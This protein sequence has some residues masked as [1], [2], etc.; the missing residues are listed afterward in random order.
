MLPT[1][2]YSPDPVLRHPAGLLREMF[3]S[4]WAGRELAWRLMV[5]NI[6]AMYR[7]TILGYLWAFLP[8]IVAAGTF[9][10]LNR[11]GLFQVGETGIPYPAWVLFGTFLWQTFADSLNNPMK[12]VSQSK[13]MLSKINFPREA[14]I[15]A[16]IGETIFNFGVRF[17]ILIPV[18]FYFQIAVDPL[19][20]LVFPLFLGA[21][22]A[23]GTMVGVLL[24]PIAVLYQ[25]IE[26]G[27]PMLLPFLMLFSG[28]VVP[29]APH[30]IGRTIATFNPILPVLET[31]RS[32]L[33]G[34]AADLWVQAAVVTCGT[35]LLLFI[36]WVLFRVAMPHLIAR[37]GG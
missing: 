24:T 12:Q 32:L 15:L 17:L 16:G 37:L 26:K 22:I 35:L 11:G 21:L 1:T 5:R 36:G 13:A 4:L 18:Y 28:V 2:V 19:A 6:S 33:S 9:I 20:L 10:V 14:L 23:M 29:I 34:Q 30:G 27:I 31:C 3:A 7:Q 8:P 25:D